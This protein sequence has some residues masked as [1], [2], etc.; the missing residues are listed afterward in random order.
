MTV[1]KWLN[2]SFLDRFIF[3]INYK[4]MRMGQRVITSLNHFQLF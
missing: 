4:I 3:N 2:P 1:G